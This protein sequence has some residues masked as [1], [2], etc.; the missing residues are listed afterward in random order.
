M[1]VPAGALGLDH[2]ERLA[3]V[4]PEHVVDVSVALAG[5]HAGDPELAVAW[6]VERPAGLAE[7]DVDEEVPGLRL[8][9]VVVVGAGLVGGLRGHV[10]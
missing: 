10:S 8:V 3:V 5:R 7:Q 6:L 2:G 1:G 4:A 9:V